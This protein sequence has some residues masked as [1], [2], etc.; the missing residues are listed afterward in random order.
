MPW[1]MVD[2]RDKVFQRVTPNAREVPPRFVK[3]EAAGEGEVREFIRET[4]KPV[5]ETSWHSWR[6]SIEHD[7]TRRFE[8]DGMAHAP[9]RDIAAGIVAKATKELKR[10]HAAGAPA[11]EAAEALYEDWIES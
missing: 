9:A 10:L 3:I 5:Y 11:R 8:R 1:Y 6:L 4:T 2:L 7:L